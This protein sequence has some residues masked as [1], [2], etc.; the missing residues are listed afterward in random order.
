LTATGA[1][2][3]QQAIFAQPSVIANKT[4]RAKIKLSA[5]TDQV[6]IVYNCVALFPSTTGSYGGSG[7]IINGPGN[8]LDIYALDGAQSA[9][10]AESVAL[11]SGFIVA[12][13]TYIVET[14]KAGL[15]MS[16]K[17]TRS[18]TQQSVSW[19]WDY[20]QTSDTRNLV[21]FFGAPGVVNLAGTPT[22]TEFDYSAASRP[23][24][25]AVLISDSIGENSAVGVGTTNW[26]TGW[27]YQLD[28]A[29][30]RGRCC[31]G[32]RRRHNNR[33]DLAHGH[34]YLDLGC[35]LCRAGHR[36]E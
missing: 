25:W 15:L 21:R 5:T 24:P 18:L 1:G 3:T 35:A 23:Q 9:T 2:W 19:S 7:V 27:V 10:L 29:R 26:P 32:A 30:N 22:V 6:G 20:N 17:V 13:E 14:K 11:P 31:R 12:G 16:A 33:R 4:A 34:R 28:A 36:N 8:T